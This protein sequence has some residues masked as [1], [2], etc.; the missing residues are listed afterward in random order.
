MPDDVTPGELRAPDTRRGIRPRFLVVLGAA[1]LALA[2]SVVMLVSVLS[3]NDDAPAIPTV[4]ATEEMA[5]DTVQAPIIEGNTLTYVIPAGTRARKL[6]GEEIAV[7]P[8]RIELTVGQTLVL[9][10]EDDDAH[11]AGPFFVGPGEE[12]SY[13]FTEPKVI[14]GD[15]TIHPSGR[16]EVAVVA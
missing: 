10:N 6:A 7:I 12:S 13:T 4:A 15:C 3:D 5:Y 9:R 1:V 16:F 2:G 8:A 14:A 11:V